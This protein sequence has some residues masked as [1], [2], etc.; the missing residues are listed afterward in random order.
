MSEPHNQ[1]QDLTLE[2]DEIAELARRLSGASRHDEA[3]ELLLLAL[4]LDPENLSVKLGLA[5]VRKLRQ[6]EGGGDSRSRSLREVLRE[7]FRRNAIDA[8]H[9][10]GLA[11]LYAERGENARAIE[12]LEVAKAKDLANP[13]HAELHGRVLFRR[14]DFD[15]AAEELGK[16]LRLNPFDREVA[17]SLGRA[18]MERK[19]F[20]AA[21]A[22]TAH[23]F[24]LLNDGDEEGGR[25]LRRRIQTLKQI[26][27][28]GNREL[29]QVFHER[30][31]QIHTA[32]DRLEWHRERFLEQGGFS[33]ASS[34]GAAA[35]AQP[36]EAATGGGAGGRIHLAAR[37]RRLRVW[38]HLS[39]EQVF[40]LTGA[41]RE[42][43]HETGGLVFAHRSQGRDLYVLE[44]GEV[45]V[46]RPT[47]YGTFTLG[48][49]EPGSMFGEA[50]YIT[51][52]DRSSDV[53]ALAACQIFRLDAAALDSLI[54]AAPDL[55]VKLYWSFW[56]SL[57]QKLRATNDQLKSFFSSDSMP[58]NFLRLR[59]QP[60]PPGG[61]PPAAPAVKVDSTDKI[62]LFREQGLSRRELMTLATFSREERFA[63][64]ASLFQ[65]GDEGAEMYVILEGK[66]MISKFIPGAGEE[67]LAILER[68]DFFGEMA[69]IDG[70]PRSADA[71]A[72]GGPLT[73]LALDQATV[74]EILAMDPDAALEFMQLLCR[75]VANR[76]REIDEKV[77]GWR[78]LS[79][80][81]NEG[82]SA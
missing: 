41:V 64:G 26:L 55:G 82:A 76:L 11:H 51:G 53:S 66:A 29:T 63:A 73:V 59:K 9:F 7:G 30:Q 24:L 12:C 40:R 70:E 48:K 5:E 25:R 15:G 56:H 42:E 78:I 36:P 44:R 62:R 45:L 20:E 58:E 37:L 72:Y 14:K 17:E 65:E 77:V 54:E 3:A 28:W 50:S 57:A 75:L 68:G 46:Q 67:A 38:S 49:L 43:I 80:E 23:A 60:A 4:R 10:L 32:F 18:E 16:A 31:E 34:F 33:P 74:R 1:P 79:G 47:A 8:A 27:G 21:L 19:Q 22:A 35:P 61:T 13:A 69:L 39:D 2:V 81:R 71:R 6:L 52:L